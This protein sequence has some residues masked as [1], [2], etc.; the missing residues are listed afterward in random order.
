MDRKS[1][2]MVQSQMNISWIREIFGPLDQMF[3]V[4][5]QGYYKKD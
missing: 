3:V 4:V 1:G 2:R 5:E